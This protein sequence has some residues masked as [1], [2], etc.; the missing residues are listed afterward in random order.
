MGSVVIHPVQK[1][2]EG[3]ADHKVSRNMGIPAGVRR[4]RTVKILAS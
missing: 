4:H 3:G 2:V 1:V